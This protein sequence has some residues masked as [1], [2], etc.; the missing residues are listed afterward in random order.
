[1][2]KIEIHSFFHVSRKHY[3]VAVCS[4]LLLTVC[5]PRIGLAFVAWGALIPLLYLAAR[6]Q[7]PACFTL[8][9]HAR[10]FHVLSL[11]YGIT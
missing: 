8:G 9:W 11:L 1:M 4:G 5:F 3:F 10:V 7:P 2:H 6:N